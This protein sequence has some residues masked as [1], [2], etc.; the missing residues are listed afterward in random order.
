MGRRWT[1]S[2][3]RRGQNTVGQNRL[4]R[5]RAR[6]IGLYG[7]LESESQNGN[8]GQEFSHVQKKGAL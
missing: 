8:S 4:K 5:C 1:G 3:F 6:P 7:E 2:G